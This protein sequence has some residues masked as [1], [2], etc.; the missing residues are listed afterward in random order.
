MVNGINQQQI[1][2]T[3]D[4]HL[5]SMFNPKANVSQDVKDRIKVEA[6]K[7]SQ[8]FE[9]IIVEYNTNVNSED[10]IDSVLAKIDSFII[11][12]E[13]LINS[14]GNKNEASSVGVI[15]Y[16]FFTQAQ[17]ELKDNYSD[18]MIFEYG[19]SNVNKVLMARL[20]K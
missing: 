9:N 13:Q 6:L 20:K 14:I 10:F 18:K 7:L 11:K 17:S 15:W 16:A 2:Q 3:I 4:G 12:Y 19:E 8:D 5:N 1:T